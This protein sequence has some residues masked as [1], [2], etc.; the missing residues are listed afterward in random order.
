MIK[1]VAAYVWDVRP[2]DPLGWQLAPVDLAYRPERG[3]EAL[4]ELFGLRR[5][6]VSTRETIS[7]CVLD[8]LRTELGLAL[9]DATLPL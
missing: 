3:M 5:F 4:D 9:V 6:S 2:V 7:N 8:Y 1:V